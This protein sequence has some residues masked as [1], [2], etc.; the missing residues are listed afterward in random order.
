MA[1][2]DQILC[3]KHNEMIIEGICASLWVDLPTHGLIGTW[4]DASYPLVSY[5]A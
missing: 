2:I 4:V 3:I 5:K 1:I